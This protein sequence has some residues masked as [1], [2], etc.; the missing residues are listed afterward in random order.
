MVMD[1]ADYASRAAAKHA[2]QVNTD[3][4]ST[5]PKAPPEGTPTRRQVEA[6]CEGVY[7]S[8]SVSWLSWAP[9][10]ALWQECLSADV[11]ASARMCRRQRARAWAVLRARNALRS[12]RNPPMRA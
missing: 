11:C 1:R 9:S 7:A 12:A 2:D 5:C 10:E 3:I 4:M 6:S 8:Q